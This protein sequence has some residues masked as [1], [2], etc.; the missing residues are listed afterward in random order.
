MS[1]PTIYKPS[2]YNARTI[3]NTGSGGGVVTNDYIIVQPIDGVEMPDGRVWSTRNLI[4]SPYGIQQGENWQLTPAELCAY[5]N[6]PANIDYGLYYNYEAVLYIHN[7]KSILIPGWDIPTMAEWRAL[8][9]S[10]GND[11]NTLQNTGFND[12]KTGQMSPGTGNWGGLTSYSF[13]WSRTGASGDF[14]YSAF[15][16]PS[17][18][19]AESQQWKQSMQSI[20]LIKDL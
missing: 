11:Y 9:N 3:Y 10:V 14:A 16:S 8:L 13:Y 12:I 5:N 18:I 4:L 2:V 15:I 19:D 7:K 20:R 1:E 6:N 17:L